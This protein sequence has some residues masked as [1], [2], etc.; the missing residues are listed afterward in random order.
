VLTCIEILLCYGS[1]ATKSGLQT[2][3]Q[4]D[5]SPNVKAILDARKKG[6]DAKDIVLIENVRQGKP[7][8]G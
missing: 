2:H 8:K 6:D 4:R 1:H 3:F 7:G 5:I